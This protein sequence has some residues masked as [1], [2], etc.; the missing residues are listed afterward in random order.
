[1]RWCVGW[2]G[3]G[4]PDVRP[5]AGRPMPGWRAAWTVGWPAAA[6]RTAQ[7][8]NTA[9]VVVGE[10]GADDDAL[11]RA[12]PAVRAQRWRDLT[13]WPG[14]YL[15]ITG[16]GQVTTLLGDLAGQ[17]P[18]YWRRAAGGVWWSTAAVPL[19][20]LDGAPVDPV[21]LGLHLAVGQP[22]VAGTT[23][24][25]R[26]VRRVPSGHV[27]LLHGA[28]VS[29]EAV[30]PVEYPPVDMEEAA[31]TVR[32]VLEM[33]VAFRLGDSP[34]ST[35]L[36]GLDST[37]LACLIAQRRPVTAVTLADRRL[38]NDDLAFAR[39]TAE[40]IEDIT[41]RVARGTAH[42]VYYAPLADPSSPVT[43]APSPYT[44]TA[45]IKDHVLRTA[46]EDLPGPGPHFTGVGGD[47]VLSA[48]PDHLADLLRE[49]RL[50]TLAV[51]LMWQ[52]RVRQRS[53]RSVWAHIRPAS[54]MA[55][56]QDLAQVAAT[57]REAPRPWRPQAEYPA[58]WVPLLATADWIT[59]PVRAHLADHLQQMATALDGPARLA[60]WQDRQDLLSL[61][62]NLTGWRT[63][64]L[65]GHGTELA[66]PYLDSTVIRACLAVPAE[67]RGSPG[68][69]KPL[70]AA[71]F[72]NGPVPCFVLDRTTKGAFSG[73]SSAGLSEHLPLITD[74]LL[75][76]DGRIA[77]LGLLTTEAVREQLARAGAGRRLAKG[78]LHTAVATELWLRQ[79]DAHRVTWWQEAPTHAR[80]R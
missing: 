34:V 78:A 64:A 31:G 60:T 46:R 16:H 33:A 49:R 77:A 55:L 39:R 73:V 32:A 71:A 47:V 72:P 75:G 3:T 7:A 15:V 36:A 2:S 53:P 42:T 40:S 58:A 66:A 70:L 1:M 56:D 25:F 65:A 20:A 43:D 10:C 28:H 54:R 24:L 9:L 38:R 62:A 80:T 26:E 6:V 79:L 18:V 76:P 17:Y 8:G 52:A 67:Q 57:L 44:V 5:A 74:L 48:D 35:D 4:P 23:S 69:F 61:G 14:A 21:G 12:L 13:D 63:L 11:E 37:T 59:P 22:D 19:A 30:E 41:H 29:T 68:R 27:L 45:T 50:R 51:H